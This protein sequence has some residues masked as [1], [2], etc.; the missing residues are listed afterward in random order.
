MAAASPSRLNGGES[1]V[2]DLDCKV[3]VVKED[4]VRLEVAVDDILGVEVAGDER[5]KYIRKITFETKTKKNLLH[6]LTS[7]TSNFNHI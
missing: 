3:V 7:L 5:K 1:E 4:V 6:P 2:A